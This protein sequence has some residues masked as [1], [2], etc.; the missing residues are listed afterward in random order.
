MNVFEIVGGVLLLVS[1]AVLVIV[2]IM[3][4]AHTAGT[5]ALTGMSEESYYGKNS[6]SRTQ[7]GM[8][9]RW[10]KVCAI[11]FFVITILINLFSVLLKYPGAQD[12]RTPSE[13][14]FVEANACQALFFLTGP[15]GRA[16]RRLAASPLRVF[17]ENKGV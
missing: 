14:A 5:N 1:C 13:T 16:F 6:K 9:V 8:L 15:R 12:G 17:C 2:I 11:A 3:Q 10:T 7:Q 4:E